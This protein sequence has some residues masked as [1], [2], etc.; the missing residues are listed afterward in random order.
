MTNYWF[1]VVN[2]GYGYRALYDPIESDGINQSELVAKGID[3][4]VEHDG[5]INSIKERDEIDRNVALA[6][7]YHFFDKCALEDALEEARAESHAVLI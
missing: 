6:N 4:K 5:V 2:T 3:F 1:T 7:W